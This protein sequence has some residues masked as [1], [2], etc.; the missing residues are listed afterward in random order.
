MKEGLVQAIQALYE[1]SS[2][3][4]LLNIHLGKFFKTSVGVRQGCFLSP[5]LFIL[6]LEKIMQETL[7]DHK[8]SI[9]TV[10]KPI[11]MPHTICGRHQSY[12]G[13]SGELQDL[14]SKLVDRARA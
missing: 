3:A 13:G 8:A 14:T 5:I 1:N 7:H 12:G 2:I 10:G 9:Y 11:I 4:V 6:F